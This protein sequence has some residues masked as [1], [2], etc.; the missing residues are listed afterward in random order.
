MNVYASPSPYPPPIKG[1]EFIK[2]LFHKG[3]GKGVCISEVRGELSPAKRDPWIECRKSY[4]F[5]FEE[6]W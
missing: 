5:V 4:A 1:V 2:F 6:S 3:R